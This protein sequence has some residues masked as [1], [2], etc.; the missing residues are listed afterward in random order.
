MDHQPVIVRPGQPNAKARISNYYAVPGRAT[1]T[2]DDMFQIDLMDD[3][4]LSAHEDHSVVLGYIMEE[5]RTVLFDP[6]GVS[7]EPPVGS[8]CLV[9]EVHFQDCVLAKNIDGKPQV[10]FYARDPHTR[11]E[12]VF[13]WPS[14]RVDV[15]WNEFDLNWIRAK[16]TKP[17]QGREICLDWKWQCP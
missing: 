10:R 17:P 8:D 14:K 2:P 4:V 7:V 1:L 11:Q 5:P 16:I 9:I 12:T 3:E 13:Q 15:R 6:P